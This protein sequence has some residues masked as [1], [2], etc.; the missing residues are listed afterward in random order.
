MKQQ[1]L[2]KLFPTSRAEN[3]RKDI[4]GIWQLQ[5][6]TLYEYWERFKKLCASCPQHQISEQLLVQY[7]Y[8]VLSV[9][10]KNMVDAASGGALVNKKPQEAS[11]LIANMAANAQQFGTR[12]DNAPRHVKEDKHNRSNLVV[13]VWLLD[14]RRICVQ[15]Y[16]KIQRSKPMQ[17]AVF[18][19]NH[20]VDMTH[21]PIPTIRDGEITRISATKIKEVNKDFHNRIT[22]NNRHLQNPLT[23]ETR[24][25]IQNLGNQISQLVTAVNNLEA[26]N[27]GKL[28]S[29][30]VVNP[31]ENASAMVLRSGKKIEIEST[32]PMTTNEGKDM[33]KEAENTS[34]EQTNV[35]P[36]SLSSDISNVVLPHFPSRLEKSKKI[37]YENEVLETFRKVEINIPLIDEIKKIPRYAKFLKDLCTNKRRLRGDEKVSVGE[38]VSAVIKNSLPNKC[39]DPVMFT[40]PCVIGNLKIERAMLDLGESINV[41]PYSIYCAL[42]LGP[43]KE[44]RVVIQLADRSNAYPEWV[45]EDVLVQVK[46]LIF[47]A[48]FY[49]LRMEEN[50]M[51]NS[52]LILLGR[53]FM[54]TTRTK[55]DVDDGTL[56]VEFDGE[57]VK[58]NIFDAMKYPSENHSICSIDV[59]DSIVR[60]V[61]EEECETENFQMYAQLNVDEEL[62]EAYG[63]SEQEIDQ[64]RVTNFKVEIPFSHKKLLPSAL[65]APKLELKSYY[66]IFIAQEDQ[67]K[68]TFTCPFGTFAYRRM[69]FGLCN[70][71]VFMDDFTVYGNSFEDFLDHLSKILRRC[72]ET[73][74]VLN[75]EKCHFMVTEGIVL[76][77]VVSSRGIEVDKAKIDLITNLP[78]PINVKEV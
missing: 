33:D 26:Q 77:H 6:E 36:T 63:I 60:E 32:S 41:M 70:A 4:C 54:K 27:S 59:V 69:S 39:K 46:E 14:I 22:T 21:I 9:F 76:G 13:Y 30:T 2:E 48:D 67:E 24:A 49:I 44:T 31:R 47:P 7:F 23:Q 28:P 57:I 78:F 71:P 16:K 29:Q 72:M 18:L 42:N 45:V 51:S 25:T 61:F 73:N 53:P 55:I 40:M 34:E 35:K 17:L 50:S 5:G 65:Q 37:D 19:D 20:N 3:I 56:S 38:N 15:H 66:Q 43:L 68:T 58:F 75:Y 8:E 52:P 10:Y 62:A 64:T 1:F 12:K 11:D 74:L